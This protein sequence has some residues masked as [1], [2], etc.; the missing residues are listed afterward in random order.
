M[1]DN[2]AIYEEKLVQAQQLLGELDVDVW[3]LF[4]RE[5][6]MAGDP[7]LKLIA[8]FDLTWELALLVDR[9]G[10]R[11]AIVG[12]YDV[13]PVE[14][15]GLFATVTSYD[16]SIRDALCDALAALDPRSIAIN[17]STSE[18][19][20][21]GLTHGMYLRLLELLEGTPYAE[22]LQSAHELV[23]R[24]R[25][26]KTTGEQAALVAALDAASGIF[27]LI[28]QSIHTGV[29]ERQLAELIHNATFEQ[30][31]GT[32]WPS[33]SCP[34]VNSGPD[35]P[36]GHAT[37]T[38]LTVQPGHLVHIDF[39]VLRDGFCSDQQRMWYVDDGSEPPEDVR[40]AWNIV[41][42]AITRGF[43]ALKPG[44]QGW[45]VDEAARAVF[46]E[47]GMPEYQHALGHGVGRSVHDGGTLLGPRWDRYGR[48]PFGI[49]EPGMVF[50]L[51]CGAATSRGYLGLEEQVI[52]EEEGARWLSPPQTE[53]YIVRGQGS[54]IGDQAGS[55]G[56]LTPDP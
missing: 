39:G 5:T 40:R 44:V 21:D 20:A 16:A 10:T 35:S 27:E 54:G 15:T 52:V 45:E 47:A 1:P 29:S 3:L 38:D 14:A 17:Y 33:S 11:L 26:S 13:Q 46:R 55:S 7:A 22:R 18:V 28:G 49:V 53:L 12:R 51:E 42:T 34:I 25:A 56:S 9:N 32:A 30:G 8:P 23:S 31:M 2:T 19:A 43:E 24:L 36:I 37:P 41:R 48:T 6:S 4:T 50:T